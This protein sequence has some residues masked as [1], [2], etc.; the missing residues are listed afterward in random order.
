MCLIYNQ[1]TKLEIIQMAKKSVRQN[2]EWIMKKMWRFERILKTNIRAM[3]R[4]MNVD[5]GEN[6]K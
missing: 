2:M 6:K 5:E 4:E 3:Q 1:L